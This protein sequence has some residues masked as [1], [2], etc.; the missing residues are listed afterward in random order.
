[1]GEALESGASAGGGSGELKTVPVLIAGPGAGGAVLEQPTSATLNAIAITR[2]MF[3]DSE[4]KGPNN[5]AAEASPGKGE[6][7]VVRIGL[8]IT[9]KI[10]RLFDG[11]RIV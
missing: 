6:R 2:Y 11:F 3:L 5:A 9:V 8:P 1:M 10:T 4:I 7:R